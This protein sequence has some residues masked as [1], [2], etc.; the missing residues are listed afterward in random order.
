[1]GHSVEASLRRAQRGPALRYAEK[2]NPMVRLKNPMQVGTGVCGWGWQPL[3]FYRANL[4]D[5]RYDAS[6]FHGHYSAL[7][8]KSFCG[9]REL[10]VGGGDFLHGEDPILLSEHPPF[11]ISDRYPHTRYRAALLVDHRADD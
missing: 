2:R 8:L 6:C 4:H 9:D 5:Q 7:G 3:M 1:M 11:R 10:V